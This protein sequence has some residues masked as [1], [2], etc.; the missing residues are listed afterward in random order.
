MHNVVRKSQIGS[1]VRTMCVCE[2]VVDRCG[3]LFCT[4]RMTS[5]KQGPESLSEKSQCTRHTSSLCAFTLLPTHHHLQNTSTLSM[6]W[7]TVCCHP[8]HIEAE[9]SSN[10]LNSLT[11]T[12]PP[13]CS[14]LLPNPSHP[15]HDQ[16]LGLLQDTFCLL[17]DTLHL[18]LS[19][20]PTA[21][22]ADSGL[23]C[24]ITCP[25]SYPRFV[26]TLLCV[27]GCTRQLHDSSC[28]SHLAP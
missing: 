1:W 27:P 4:N 6:H 28:S 24:S 3:N 11:V 13:S 22:N 23:F 7:G 18:L 15:A 26:I 2:S 14:I 9:G 10:I 19:L 20:D 17:Q 12:P 25:T 5:C 16:V 21:A 8:K